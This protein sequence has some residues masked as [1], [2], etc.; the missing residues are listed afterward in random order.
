MIICRSL[1]G[2][3]REASS[4]P[5][6]LFAVVISAARIQASRDDSEFHGHARRQ[7]AHRLHLS[8]Q[9]V[10]RRLHPEGLDQALHLPVALRTG[11]A[12][13]ACCTTLKTPHAWIVSKL[14]N[15]ARSVCT[16]AATQ[17]TIR[18][19]HLVCTAGATPLLQPTTR[20]PLPGS[21]M[22]CYISFSMCPV[23]V[24]L[25]STAM[26]RCPPTPKSVP[27]RSTNALK[28]KDRSSAVN[29]S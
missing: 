21:M 13:G 1:D 24:W 10:R 14:G 8:H 11:C 26:A 2:G 15:S 12:L 6:R 5:P 7:M 28:L 23:K 18:A 29:P 4:T 3:D 17:L 22:G 25:V 19:R 20:T 9:L 27:T 16:T